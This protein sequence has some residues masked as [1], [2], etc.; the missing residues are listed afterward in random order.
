MNRFKSAT[1]FWAM[2]SI[3]LVAFLTSAPLHAQEV[4]YPCQ[5][6]LHD[7]R[8]EYKKIFL[9]DWRFQTSSKTSISLRPDSNLAGVSGFVPGRYELHEM[10]DS[11]HWRAWYVYQV[12]GHHFRDDLRVNKFN[13]HFNFQTKQANKVLISLEGICRLN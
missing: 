1:D 10:S 13:G 9:D 8:D 3:A 12:N 4:S 2:F 7:Y 5:G 11:I 6:L